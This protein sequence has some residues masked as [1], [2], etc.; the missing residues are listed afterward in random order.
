LLLSQGVPML[1][2]GD[3]MG[4]TQHGNNNAY[5]H[6]NA[7]SW[8]DW[9]LAEVGADLVDFTACL[10]ELRQKH[11]AFRR[12]KFF[13]GR[14]LY[15]TDN[16]DIAW[17][18]PE[19]VEMSH[20]NWGEGA[21]K[22][23]AVYLNGDAL[24]MVDARGQAVTDETFLL[25]LNAADH[26]QQFT[27]PATAWADGWTR[28]VDTASGACTTD[29]EWHPAGSATPVEGRALLLLQRSEPLAD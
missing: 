17:F 12:P 3:E 18:T 15:G 4:R 28:L 9:E 6:D 19:G 7:L 2:A 1:L 16:K 21:A 5:C 22:S 11:P 26:A 23:V 8:L 27:L 10:L 29:G 14:P 13:Q 24:D 20:D 25:L